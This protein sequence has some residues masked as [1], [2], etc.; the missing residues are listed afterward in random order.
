M[1][2]KH[3]FQKLEA[4]LQETFHDQQLTR[5]ENRALKA[6][7]K[8]LHGHDDTLRFVRNTAFDIARQ[9]L[10]NHDA[11]VALHWLEDVIK[12][13]DNARPKTEQAYACFSPGQDC[14]NTLL[15]LIDQA[16]SSIDICVFTITDN[17][18]DRAIRNAHDRGINIRIITDDDKSMDL[19]SDVD[20]LAAYGIRVITDDS[21]NHMHH[22]FAVFDQKTLLNGSFNWTRSA[23]AQNEENIIVTDNATLV[24]AF[25][26]QFNH[27]WEELRN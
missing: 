25:C 12:L 15:K 10:K 7:L 16:A 21:P 19:G 11:Q 24:S 26:R 3:D 1:P 27:L 13:V 14:L 4:I 5:S 18:I 20:N 22:K 9:A 6:V 2:D 23:S 17:R 8:D